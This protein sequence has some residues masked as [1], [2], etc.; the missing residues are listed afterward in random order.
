MD[1][2]HTQRM[3]IVCTLSMCTAGRQWRTNANVLP[4]ESLVPHSASIERGADLVAHEQLA[5]MRS[6]AGFAVTLT[7]ATFV[8]HIAPQAVVL[9]WKWRLV[10][11]FVT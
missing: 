8:Q 3:V 4:F 2:K 10:S 1:T 9:C 7:V 5:P 6:A 11:C